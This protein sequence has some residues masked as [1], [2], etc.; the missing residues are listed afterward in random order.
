MSSDL[1]LTSS[2]EH[3][4]S[5]RDLKQYAVPTYSHNSS[6]IDNVSYSNTLLDKVPSLVA[7]KGGNYDIQPRLENLNHSTIM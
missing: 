6:S 4:L 7:R 2:V 5:N 3:Q 1:E